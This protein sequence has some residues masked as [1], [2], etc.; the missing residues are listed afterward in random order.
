MEQD[1]IMIN[2]GFCIER[3]EKFYDGSIDRVDLQKYIIRN[4]DTIVPVEDIDMSLAGLVKAG[5]I[6]VYK[7][8]FGNIAYKRFIPART[9]RRMKN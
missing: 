2:A 5:F 8:N 3:S 1:E 4:D 6:E 9:N 7:D